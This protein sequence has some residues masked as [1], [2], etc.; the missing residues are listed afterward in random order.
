ME[1]PEGD[2]FDYNHA[3]ISFRNEEIEM[4]TSTNYDNSFRDSN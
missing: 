3:S 1:E 2:E 4:P